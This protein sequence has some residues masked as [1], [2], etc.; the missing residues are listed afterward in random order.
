VP[1]KCVSRPMRSTRFGQHHESATTK[2]DRDR[3]GT[4]GLW[5]ACAVS[6]LYGTDIGT[7]PRL[8]PPIIQGY[9]VVSL[10]LSNH[11]WSQGFIFGGMIPNLVGRCAS[12]MTAVGRA[13]APWLSEV[14]RQFKGRNLPES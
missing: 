8:E 2:G 14:R 10:D 4:R 3:T 13:A 1:R 9:G 5:D 11:T 7:S 6:G 12:S